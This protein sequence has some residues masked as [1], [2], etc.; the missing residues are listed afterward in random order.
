MY[1][2][3]GSVVMWRASR[4]SP[5]SSRALSSGLLLQ[6]ARS[7]WLQLPAASRLRQLPLCLQPLQLRLCSC[8]QAKMQLA[9]PWVMVSTLPGHR[10]LCTRARWQVGCRA[11]LA[12][13]P[14]ASG[15][16]RHQM[17]GGCCCWKGKP[18][19]L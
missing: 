19:P 16:C 1:G 7:H 11:Q 3:S 17:L 6:L 4:Q 10:L 14:S 13:L 2:A 18:T 5:A 15:C 12:G 9:S 8:R